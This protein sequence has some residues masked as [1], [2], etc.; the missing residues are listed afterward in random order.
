MVGERIDEVDFR[1]RGS[2]LDQAVNHLLNEGL[3]FRAELGKRGRGKAGIEQLAHACVIGRVHEDL[4]ILQHWTHRTDPITRVRG[5]TIQIRRNP[6]RREALVVETGPHVFVEGQH[7]GAKH[8]AV[9]NRI[10]VP[11]VAIL[12]IRA[13]HHRRVIGA[14]VK[15]HVGR[16]TL[17]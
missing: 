14:E 3:D 4:P 6:V 5:K 8:V 10:H 7:P 17:A 13:L 16:S 1:A 12:R 15:C 11:K 2:F 9:V